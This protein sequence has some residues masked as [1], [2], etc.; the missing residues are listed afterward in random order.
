MAVDIGKKGNNPSAAPSRS[1]STRLR[2]S[3]AMSGR[4][5][6]FARKNFVFDSP[7]AEVR[8]ARDGA[9]LERRERVKFGRKDTAQRFL[10]TA[11][12][13]DGSPLGPWR[14]TAPRE[15][16]GAQP[17]Q[18]TTLAEFGSGDRP[19]Q[20]CRN[21]LPVSYGCCIRVPPARRNG[22]MASKTSTK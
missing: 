10:T 5:A 18:V 7:P 8:W 22:E 11:P 21:P 6:V 3:V 14:S 13:M 19:P 2:L 16:S 17:A 9:A 15:L 12:L 4:W 1:V 20:K